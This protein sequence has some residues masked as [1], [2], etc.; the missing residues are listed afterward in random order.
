MSADR[1]AIILA[2]FT[3]ISSTF[4]AKLRGLPPGLAEDRP[5]A[6]S[7]T[8]AQI[9]CHVALANEWI[10]GVLIGTVPVGEPAPAG[11]VE[12]FNAT[13]LPPAEETFPDLVPPYPVSRDVALERLRGSSQRAAR[14]VAGLTIDQGA[15][16]CVKLGFGVLSVYELAD[17][18]ATHMTRH[19]A[20]V[21]RTIGAQPGTKTMAFGSGR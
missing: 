7:W 13:L 10:A 14:A 11:F 16:W 6:Q 8:L 18:A 4:M 21:D 17:F 2:R 20:Q 9:G 1:A 3:T 12:R 5:D 19:M 15:G